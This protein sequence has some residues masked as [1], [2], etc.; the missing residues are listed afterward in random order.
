MLAIVFSLINVSSIAKLRS[1]IIFVVLTLTVSFMSC[2]LGLECF[3]FQDGDLTFFLWQCINSE[4]SEFWLLT[5][6]AEPILAERFWYLTMPQIKI[7]FV[8]ILNSPPQIFV[9]YHCFFCVFSFHRFIRSV[10]KQYTQ[11]NNVLVSFLAIVASTFL[12]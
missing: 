5:Y 12:K 9:F 1:A 10:S 4:I 6:T 8:A 11:I 3:P 7:A 2:W